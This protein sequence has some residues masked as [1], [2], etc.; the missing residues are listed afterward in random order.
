MFKNIYFTNIIGSPVDADI[1][2]AVVVAVVVSVV[3]ATEV[4]I[5]TENIRS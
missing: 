4:V 2:V 1:F 5:D 3:V